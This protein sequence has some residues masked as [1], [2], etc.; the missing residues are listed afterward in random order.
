MSEVNED[1]MINIGET[2]RKEILSGRYQ[3]DRRLPGVREF[4]E[5]FSCSRG[6][7]SN[8][9]KTLS[10]EGLIRTEHGRG[11]FLSIE[12]GTPRRQSSRMVGAVL[13]RYSWMEQMEC[14]R[15]EYLK[16]GWLVSLYCSSDDLQSPEAE[17]RF[18]KMA[19][20][21]NFAG[22][23]LTG[24]PL[25]PLNTQLYHTLRKAGLKIVHLTHYKQDMTCEAA[26]L[27]DYRMAGAMAY[28][29]AAASGRKRFAVVR[30]DGALPPSTALRLDGIALMNRSQL[31]EELPTLILSSGERFSGNAEARAREFFRECGPL[32]DL[33][34][35]A[36]DC[37]TLHGLQQWLSRERGESL[38]Q[39]KLLSMSDT[40]WRKKDMDHI[41]FDYSMSLRM[42]MDYISDDEIS[43]LEPYQ[44]MISP[45]YHRLK[46]Q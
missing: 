8:A 1:Q 45:F 21:Q 25:E 40:H 38:Q 9:L 15:E 18:L 27:P 30:T 42:A 16:Q 22:V 20:E 4:A 10:E 23:I 41:G 36:D 12:S 24:T 32:E 14:L 6:T 17:R 37:A 39:L 44:R 19:L 2:L 3:A 13:L 31:L 43:P 5:R 11:T 33:I 35:L 29:I 28:S 46:Q 7:V 34:L 26:I